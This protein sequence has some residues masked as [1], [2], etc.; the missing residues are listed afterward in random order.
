MRIMFAAIL[1]ACF[2]AL[3]AAAQTMQTT[4]ERPASPSIGAAADLVDIN[5]ASAAELDKLPGIGRAR[6][7]AIVRNRP[8]KA[9]DDLLRRHIIPESVYNDIKG[10]IIAHRG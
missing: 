9:K 2:T 8:Y 6:A 10:K 5:A 3:P 4:P 1:A 7:D